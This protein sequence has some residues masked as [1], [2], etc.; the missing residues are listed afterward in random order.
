MA[1]TQGQFEHNLADAL[2]KAGWDASIK[3]TKE[4]LDIVGKTIG[5]ALKKDGGARVRGIGN[6]TAKKVPARKARK[7]I[8]PFTKEEQVF[9]A[10]PASTKVTIRPGRD[11]K[12][13]V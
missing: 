7:G 11:L 9:K 6:F 1:L 4:L 8:N 2:N 3:D 5:T 13:A 10:K 12:A